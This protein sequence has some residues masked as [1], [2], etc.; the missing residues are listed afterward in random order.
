MDEELRIYC[1]RLFEACIAQIRSGKPGPSILTSRE[2][3]EALIVLCERLRAKSAAAAS[4]PLRRDY[5]HMIVRAGAEEAEGGLSHLRNWLRG[6][7]EIVICDPYFL[8]FSP[9]EI[10]PDVVAYAE[11][12][13]KLIPATAKRLDLYTNSYQNVVRPVVLNALKQG[14]NVR[15][16]SSDKLHDRFVLKDGTYGKMIGTSFGGFGQKFF[17]MLDLEPDDVATVRQEL[18]KLCPAPAFVRRR[19]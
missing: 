5:L 12:L 14:R 6:S 15:H 7:R 13:V 8:K 19:R 9:S 10:Y 18:Q 17:S 16:F 11:A 4:V 3:E 1:L 2:F